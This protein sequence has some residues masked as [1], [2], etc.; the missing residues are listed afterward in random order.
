MSEQ[1]REQKYKG[2]YTKILENKVVEWDEVSKSAV[3]DREREVH[4]G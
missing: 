1:L 4:R 2:E 3:V